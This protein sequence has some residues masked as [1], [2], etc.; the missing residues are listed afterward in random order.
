VFRVLKR[1][2]ASDTIP[3]MN[4]IDYTTARL[5][6]RDLT[7]TWSRRAQASPAN[8]KIVAFLSA[9]VCSRSI[10]TTSVRKL[11]F[12]RKP[13]S[14]EEC[15][16]RLKEETKSLPYRT[17]RLSHLLAVQ[18]HRHLSIQRVHGDL[19]RALCLQRKAE[20]SPASREFNEWK[21]H[22]YPT[23]VQRHDL[24]YSIE[25]GLA[26]AERSKAP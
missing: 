21:F 17:T 24:C 15:L 20:S 3:L 19:R 22:L 4:K 5:N 7:A 1:Q 9:S 16:A 25:V 18:R 2:T 8:L 26:F 12:S 6:Q 23:S 14:S 10:E 11:E 13:A